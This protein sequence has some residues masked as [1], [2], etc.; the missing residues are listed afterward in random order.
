MG[1]KRSWELDFGGGEATI[2]HFVEAAASQ[3]RNDSAR[4][5]L[6]IAPTAF[7][8]YINYYNDDLQSNCSYLNKITELTLLKQ[9]KKP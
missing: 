8:I 5:I 1:C 9:F 4:R 2:L 6:L 3:T 7:I